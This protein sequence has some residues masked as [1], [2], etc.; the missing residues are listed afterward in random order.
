MADVALGLGVGV[1]RRRV[2]RE[3]PAGI[4][5]IAL[6][7]V[8]RCVAAILDDRQ[9]VEAKEA[10]L[11]FFPDLVIDGGVPVDRA[12]HCGNLHAQLV[13]GQIV[14]LI[15][16]ADPAVDPAR[17]EAARPGRVEQGVGVSSEGHVE[18][19][20]KAIALGALGYRPAV[21]EI[22]DVTARCSCKAAGGERRIGPVELRIAQRVATC[23]QTRRDTRTGT[24]CRIRRGV[25]IRALE[26]GRIAPEPSEPE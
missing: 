25:V 14:G 15:G 7:A 5:D 3:A 10:E 12:A 17:S 1:R 18:A 6:D 9:R 13:V 19:V 23:R 22:G 11:E 16:I 2:E 20:S 24:T 4:A 8:D 26:I 21:Y